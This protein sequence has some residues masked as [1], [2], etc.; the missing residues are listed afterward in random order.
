MSESITNI[1]LPCARIDSSRKEPFLVA[2]VRSLPTV[3]M[4]CVLHG[5]IFG[6]LRAPM[7]P[8]S[9]SVTVRPRVMCYPVLLRYKIFKYPPVIM[10]L[11]VNNRCAALQCLLDLEHRNSLRNLRVSCYIWV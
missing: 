2:R 1:L 8:G 10:K 11:C 4:S 7:V 9:N 6:K 5:F 3:P